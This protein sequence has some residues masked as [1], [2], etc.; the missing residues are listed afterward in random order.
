MPAIGNEPVLNTIELAA[1]MER[2]GE[3]LQREAIA[4]R[5]RLQEVLSVFGRAVADPSPWQC[6]ESSDREQLWFHPAL[7]QAPLG[8]CPAVA[9]LDIPHAIVATDGS[10]ITPSHHEVAYCSLVNVGRVAIEYGGKRLP[11]LDSTPQ[12]YYRS[13]ELNRGRPPGTSID[14]ML[15][16]RRTQAELQ[17]LTQLAL[18]WSR[19]SVPAIAL[20]DGALIHWGLDAL[21]RDW[22]PQWLVPLLAQFDRLQQARIPLAGYISASRSSET[23]AYLRLGLCPFKTCECSI[24]CGDRQLYAAPCTP[25]SV[26]KEGPRS[27]GDVALWSAR[28]APYQRSPIWRSQAELL[29][30][31]GAHHHIHFCYLHVGSEV[32]RVE[33]PAWVATDA[34]LLDRALG[35]IL[36]QVQR[37]MGYPV[38]LAE[39]HHLAV[40]RGSERQFFFATLQREMQRLGLQEPSVSLKEANKRQG[41][42]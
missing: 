18:D 38:A 23:I 24:H 32:A 35:A 25:Y 15:A 7:P 13:E 33:F 34:A 21:P 2:V 10:Q 6:R 42:A 9:P 20:V 19:E 4:A 31:Y 39:A 3:H 29:D 11:L 5:A 17:E 37:G 36:T 1:Q 30:L 8:D 40:V 22:Q 14:T 27:L 16:L 26:S 12:V 28:L 41:V